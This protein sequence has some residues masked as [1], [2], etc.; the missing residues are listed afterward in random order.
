MTIA[1]LFGLVFWLAARTD[2][3]KSRHQWRGVPTRPASRLPRRVGRHH[4]DDSPTMK[5][6][7]PLASD[8]VIVCPASDVEHVGATED[9]RP[10]AEVAA[11]DNTNAEWL[12][13]MEM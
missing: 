13:I 8:N 7:A 5:L 11:V 3:A 10:V 9:W 6:L 4:V 12:K 2:A 1:A